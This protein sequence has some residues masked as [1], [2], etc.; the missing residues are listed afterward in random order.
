MVQIRRT[1]SAS[2]DFIQLVKLLDAYLAEKDG[3]DHLFYS[4]FNK[5]DRIKHVIVAY[6]D[7][8]PVGCGA[9]KEYSPD[10]ME[11]KRMYTSPAH[12]G[13][14][15][16][17]MVLRELEKWVAE[18]H[19]ADCILETG[20]RQVEAIRLYEKTGYQRIPNYG[21]YIGVQNS[22]CFQKSIR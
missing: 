1:D 16:A 2:P 11:I 10:I 9:I 13:S 6:S 4:Q 3:A 19:Y 8:E 5:I 17:G 12:R 7:N 18:M 14:G 15:I 22:V 21:Q 20:I